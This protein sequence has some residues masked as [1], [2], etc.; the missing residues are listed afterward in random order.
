MTGRMN[1]SPSSEVY[2]DIETQLSADEVGGWKNAHLMKIALAVTWC[3]AD[4]FRRWDESSV[5]EMIDYLL[6]FDRVINFNGDSFD[7]RVLSSYR[8]VAGLRLKSFD[9]LTDLLA[10]LGHRVSLDSI[11]QATLGQKKTADG[12]VALRWW[13]EG[14]LEELGA[15]CENDVGVLRDIVEYGRSHGHVRY[16]DRSGVPRTVIVEW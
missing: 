8:D 12:L 4:G 11:A 6:A 14:R 3:D 15:Y 2:Y 10:R 7:S 5:S 16:F 1:S 13:I 9:I